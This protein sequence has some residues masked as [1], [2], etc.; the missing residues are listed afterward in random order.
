MEMLI[1]LAIMALAVALVMPRG[2]AML[3]GMTTHAVFFDFQRQISDLRRE[4]YASQTPTTV[5][6][7]G[8]ADPADAG[9]IVIPLRAAWS[10]RL[11][12]PIAI[13]DGGVCTPS[14]VEVLKAGRPVMHLTMGD[15]ACHFIRQD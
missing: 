3:D 8:D 7:T 10:Y 5:R 14:A 9:D 13:S 15:S 4:A 11:E 1:V 12:R 6:G 2:E